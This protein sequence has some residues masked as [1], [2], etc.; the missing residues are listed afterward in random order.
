MIYFLRKIATWFHGRGSDCNDIPLR[1]GWMCSPSLRK[2]C[3]AVGLGVLHPNQALPTRG[4]PVTSSTIALETSIR[5][6]QSSELF[7]V[8]FKENCRDVSRWNPFRHQK[9]SVQPTAWKIAKTSAFILSSCMFGGSYQAGIPM[10]VCLQRYVAVRQI[11][12]SKNGGYS[13]EY[14]W[15][16][17]SRVG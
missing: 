15:T 1:D 13:I 7:F 10:F 4:R 12:N 14:A 3:T 5:N 6:P 9:N 16:T 2:S 11:S 17:E 8:R